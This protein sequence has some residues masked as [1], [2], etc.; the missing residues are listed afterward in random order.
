[1]K[2]LVTTFM[3]LWQLP[4]GK[5]ALPQNC[6]HHSKLNRASS[7]PIWATILGLL[8]LSACSNSGQVSSEDLALGRTIYNANCA[9]CHGVEGEGQPNWKVPDENGQLPAPPHDET[10]HTWHHPDALLLQIIAQG[11]GAPNSTMPLYEGKLTQEEMAATLAYIK[12]FWGKQERDFQTQMTEQ[13]EA[14]Q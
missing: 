6:L 5:K 12:T 13:Y 11:S 14:Q 8:F 10:G 9:A 3:H 7:G 1:M 2:N 4:T